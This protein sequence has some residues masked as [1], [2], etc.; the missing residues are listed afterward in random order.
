MWGGAINKKTTNPTNSMTRTLKQQLL[1]PRYG[2][3]AMHY[4]SKRSVDV[5]RT[6]S[7]LPI[8]YQ[9]SYQ[10]EVV[11]ASSE[12]VQCGKMIKMQMVGCYWVV[13]ERIK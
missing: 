12:E 13:S 1:N 10:V 8:D 9:L 7:L 2:L 6:F 4:T 11:R 3:G 5:Y